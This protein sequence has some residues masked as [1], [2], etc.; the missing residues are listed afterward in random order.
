[1]L[2]RARHRAPDHGPDACRLPAYVPRACVCWLVYKCTRAPAGRLL[3]GGRRRCGCQGPGGKRVRN[4]STALARMRDGVH[5]ACWC[6]GMHLAGTCAPICTARVCAFVTIGSQLCG[7]PWPG[8]IRWRGCA[9]VRVGAR[10]RPHARTR[11]FGWLW[12][13]KACAHHHTTHHHHHHHHATR[14]CTPMRAC[15]FRQIR[16]GEAGAGA[17]QQCGVAARRG[18]RQPQVG[19]CP[20]LIPASRNPP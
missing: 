9:W 17:E 7:M 6:D 13:R 3:P 16:E 5:A 15:V 2:H 20:N 8:G 12:C 11:L 14:H 10:A 18:A 1:M 19:P 4:T